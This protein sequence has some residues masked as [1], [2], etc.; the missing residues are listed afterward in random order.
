MDASDGRWQRMRTGT[1]TRSDGSIAYRTVQ[2]EWQKYGTSTV[3]VFERPIRSEAERDAGGG[4]H[5]ASGLGMLGA[6]TAVAAWLGGVC[7]PRAALPVG[8]SDSC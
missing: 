7:G 6:R 8:H 4:W 1:R 3:P 5:Q 2:Y